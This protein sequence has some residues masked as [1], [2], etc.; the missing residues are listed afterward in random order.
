MFENMVNGGDGKRKHSKS[1]FGFHV[2]A[3]THK[4]I[5]KSTA[6]Y[7]GNMLRFPI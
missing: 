7:G 3:H 5:R 2:C 1:T 6:L 4:F